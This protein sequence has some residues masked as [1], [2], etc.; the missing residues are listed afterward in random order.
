[1]ADGTGR[2]FR[3]PLYGRPF[4]DP[5]VLKFNGEYYAYGTPGA[6]GLPVLRSPDLISWQEAG[7]V[8]GPPEPGL[9]HWAPE[10]AYDNGRFFLYYSTGGGEG[11]DQRLRVAG[12]T[13]PTGPFDEDFGLL[14]AD[15]PFT[16]DAHPFCDDD[17]QWY[18]F[19]SRDFLEVDMT[20]LA[21]ER[22]TVMRPHADWHIY[23]RQR[24]WYGKVWDWYTVEGPFVRKHDGRYWCFYSGG[25]WKAENYGISSAVA[26]HPMGPYEPVIADDT[27]DVLRTVPG[28]V[29]GPGHGSVALAP[30]NL[31]EFLVYHAWDLQHTGRFLHVDP[32]AW[33][34]GRPVSPGPR[35]EPQPCPPEPL[36]RDLVEEPAPG[37]RQ[38]GGWRFR[39]SWERRSD[40]LV[41]P[42]GDP[43][44]I[45]VLDLA[46]P[47]AYLFA[48]NLATTALPVPPNS[49]WGVVLAYQDDGN[50][51]TVSIDPE[52][53]ELT[54][55]TVQHGERKEGGGLR[56][57]RPDFASAAYHQ[58]MVRHGPDATT[59]A[60]D[61]MS[62]G[63]LARA[64]APEGRIG[65]WASHAGLSAA[66]VT[67]TALP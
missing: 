26:D 51:I 56:A 22:E 45:A 55:E 21:G 25:A 39:G 36:F 18:L 6:G 27:A 61:G 60:L 15:D 32:L 41:H 31:T 35:T 19:Y 1:M 49:R 57:L 10:V 3:N 11:E 46:L 58:L 47:P 8:L 52:R 13:S 2:T 5:F 53:G 42:G 29:I 33:D 20:S 38:A 64:I 65:V 4:A 67:V 43:C 12:A 37:G 62:M 17:G 48:S 14:D 40:R 23:E 54:W 28:K 50:H 44:A 7:E 24:Q 63:G 66:G 59:V 30:D 9:A 16:I 34:R